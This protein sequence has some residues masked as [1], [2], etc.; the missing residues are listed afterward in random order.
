MAR[1]YRTWNEKLEVYRAVKVFLP[2]GHP[3]LMKRFETEIKISAK[4][5]HP[6]IIETYTVGEWNGLPY[7]EM[8]L[9]EGI[10]LEELITRHRTLPVDVTVAICM[11][12]ADA[13]FY[14]HNQQ[15]LLYGKTYNG[16]IHRDLKPANIMISSNGTVKLLDFGIARPAEVG[17]HTV[18]GHIVG[19]LPY[20]SPE[21]LDDN[22]IDHR[23]DIYSLGTIVYEALTGEKTFPQP[24]ITV[25]LKMK[26]IGEY[27]KFETFSCNVPSSLV[28]IVE[29]CL[30]EN[31]DDRYSTTAELKKA[32]TPIFKKTIPEADGGLLILN[33]QTG[34]GGTTYQEDR[35]LGRVSMRREALD[36]P[37]ALFTIDIEERNQN[38]F[39]QLKWD[40]TAYTVPFTVKN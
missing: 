33:T 12:V 36:G 27:R 30:S 38:A 10:S 14:A 35:D 15:F 6:N 22:G 21:Q 18:A 3:E 23:S 32:L 13:L 11:Q 5:H 25:L 28:K 24:T 29:K 16:I 31:R 26:S 20:L 19:T 1:V 40:Q 34:Q 2:T 4:L 9:V 7:I 37:V 8:E 17:L 39:L